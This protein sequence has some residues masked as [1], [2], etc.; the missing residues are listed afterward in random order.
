MK[1]SEKYNKIIISTE[2]RTNRPGFSDLNYHGDFVFW[3]YKEKETGDWV[4]EIADETAP[5]EKRQTFQVRL[6][7]REVSDYMLKKYF[8]LI[9]EQIEKAENEK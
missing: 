5:L 4:G 2:V 8:E 6:S 9:T 7:K 1:L 3:I